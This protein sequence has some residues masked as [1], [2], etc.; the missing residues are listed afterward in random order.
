MRVAADSYE[1]WLL[2]DHGMDAS[3]HVSPISFLI[4]TTLWARLRENSGFAIASII[5]CRGIANAG[6]VRLADVVT[7]R[8]KVHSSQVRRGFGRAYIA[9]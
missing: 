9:V 4:G 1:G 6:L 2:T 7:A 3:C 5:K 8:I